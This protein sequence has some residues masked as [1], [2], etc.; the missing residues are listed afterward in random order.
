VSRRFD[1]VTFDCY[2]TLADWETGISESLTAE[3]SRHGVNLDR[4]TILEAHARIEPRVQVGPFR[5]YREVL[6]ETAVGIAQESGWNLV[7]TEAEFLP[8][9]LKN[10][11]V[12][13]DTNA[14]LER[15]VDRGYALGIL[16]NVDDQLLAGT[17]RQFSVKFE[18]IVTA[19]QVRSYKPADSHFVEARRQI[20]DRRWLHAAQSWFHD[21]EPACALGI[22][23]AWV[24]RKHEGAPGD[25]TPEL[26]VPDMAGLA[27]RLAP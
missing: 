22:P 9:S 26:Q 2:G 20:G 16:S 21:V 7:P 19:E 8:E 17:L 10:W 25:A 1:I 13:D 24:N 27:E 11:R 6:I 3:A 5:S 18:L 12:F 14:A 15:L 4:E 23:A